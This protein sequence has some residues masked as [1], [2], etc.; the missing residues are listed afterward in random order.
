MHALPIQQ[1]KNI[2]LQAR[3]CALEL[4]VLWLSGIVGQVGVKMT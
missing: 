4:L 1:Y 3:A 2:P